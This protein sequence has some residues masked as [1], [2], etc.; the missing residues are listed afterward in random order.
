MVSAHL[1]LTEDNHVEYYMT[2]STICTEF[3]IFFV[4]IQL[5]ILIW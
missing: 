1:P 2:T 3:F 5:F 4:L